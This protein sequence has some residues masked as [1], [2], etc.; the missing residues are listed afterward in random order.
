MAIYEFRCEDCM[1]LVKKS[2]PISSNQKT[3][4]CEYCSGDAKRQ[5]S[6]S[7]FSIKGFSAKNG[8]SKGEK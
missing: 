6:V 5:I 3:V 4:R 8:Y 7:N 1:K 2:L